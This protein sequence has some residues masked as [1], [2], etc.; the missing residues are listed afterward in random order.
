MDTDIRKTMPRP[1]GRHL[2]LV[3]MLWAATLVPGWGSANP[4]GRLPFRTY[5]AEAGLSNQAVT[6]LAQDTR[7]FL[8]VGTQ[9]HLFRFDGKT[10]QPFGMR[11]GLPSGSITAL[12]P[13]STSGLWV[14]TFRGLARLQGSRF[15]TLP[16]PPVVVHQIRTRGTQVWAA[17]AAG[18]LAGSETEMLTQVSGWTGEAKALWLPP[19]GEAVWASSGTSLRYREGGGSW[20][21]Q[22]LPEPAERILDLTGDH[23]GRL[24]VRTPT[25]L[26]VRDLQGFHAIT[27]PSLGIPSEEAKLV[28]D[29]LNRL[30]VP[31]NTGLWLLDKGVWSNIHSANGLPMGSPN[32]VL[33]DR[34]GSLWVAG[35]GVH[36]LQGRG[37]WQIHREPEGLPH[38]NIWGIT[39]DASGTLWIATSGGLARATERGW[40]PFRDS[41]E[42]A[43]RSIAARKAGGIWACGPEGSLFSADRVLRRDDAGLPPV[44]GLSILE[45][46]AGRLWVGTRQR[47]LYCRLP[48]ETRFQRV[49]LPGGTEG[50]RIGGLAEGPDGTIWAA[51]G[52][53]LA[54]F[55]AG[56][57]TRFTEKDG[58]RHPHVEAVCLT[59]GGQI[60][61]SYYEP[62]G[63]SRFSMEGPNLRL[64]GHE[65]VSTGLGTDM[66]YFMGED[67]QNRIWVGTGRGVDVLTAGVIQHFGRLDGLA[68]EDCNAGAFLAEIGDVIWVGTSTGLTRGQGPWPPSDPAPAPVLLSARLEDQPLPLEEPAPLRLPHR[69][70]DL[71]VRF[72]V[73]TFLH[74]SGMESRYRFMESGE[75]WRTTEALELHLGNLA[76]GPH[77]LE[78]QSRSKKGP[79][80]EPVRL[81]LTLVAAWW[82]PWWVRILGLALVLV[83]LVRVL[84]HHWKR[85]QR[86]NLELETLLNLADQLTREL[87]VANL[88][89]QQ[90]STTDPLTGLRNRRYLDSNLSN[91][92]AHVERA[93]RTFQEQGL[94]GAPANADLVFMIVDIDFFKRVNDTHGHMAGDAVLQQFAEILRRATRGSDTIIRW[95]GEEFMVEARHSQRR[96]IPIVA[97][98]I[99]RSVEMWPF[100]LPDGQ[101]IRCTCSL[102]FAPYP[103]HTNHPLTWQ[104]VVDLADQFLYRAKAEGRNRWVGQVSQR[105]ADGGPLESFSQDS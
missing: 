26:L 15:R 7:G 105:E 32:T 94:D 93:Y 42:L 63:F 88:A 73:P 12:A 13:D 45:D 48:G 36:R 58:L 67:A 39:R 83:G 37:H 61:A 40:A 87:E 69:T 11:E 76:P 1:P 10:F 50:E 16:T 14:G 4:P 66:V 49:P 8:W 99:R 3:F 62:L 35:Q 84:Q 41:R 97:E 17:T 5:G 71:H 65:D 104:E 57:W 89:L 79:W 74:E 27:P 52:S 78:I 28:V 90:E 91:D 95:G 24:F 54:R 60:L 86:R 31:T 103:F 92:L 80:G 18:L 47:G 53:G 100:V 75:A 81:S 23:S 102:G 56:T 20:L 72:A 85:L 9:G 44:Q 19:E 38:P 59:R 34:E 6:S 43:F 70:G 68:G 2:F 82:Q 22:P 77:T 98:R 25:R 101:V 46:R 33:L 51:G 64:L 29:A 30:W 55:E 96:D 21:T